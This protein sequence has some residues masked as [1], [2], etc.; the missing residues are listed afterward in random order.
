LFTSNRSGGPQIYQVSL[1]SKN[2]SRISY[3]GDYNARASFTPDGKQIVMIHRVGG[4]FNI[5]LL[6]LDAGT[7]RVLSSAST[8]SASPSIA[9]NGSMIMYDTLYG[10]RNVLAMVSV[11]GRVQIRLPARNG[12][13]QDPAWS[14]FIT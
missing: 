11:D 6:N 13:A 10:G 7:V 12:E 4:I 5:A 3:D 9:P 2:V 14:P 8:D 1:A